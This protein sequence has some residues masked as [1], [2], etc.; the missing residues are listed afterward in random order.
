M[1]RLAII[2]RVHQEWALEQAGRV[3]P[4]PT[5]SHNDPSQYTEGVETLSAS[6]EAQ[7]DLARR[8]IQALL[9]AGYTE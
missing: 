2:A 5:Y 9:E 7:A 1:S 3:E 8:T 4:D 6:P